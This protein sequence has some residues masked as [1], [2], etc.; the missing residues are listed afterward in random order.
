L[1]T[2][3]ILFGLGFLLSTLLSAQEVEYTHPELDWYTIR[4]EHFQ[5][6]YHQGAERSARVVAKVAEDIYDPVTSFYDWAPDGN[7]HFI[8]KDHDDNSNGAAYYYDNKVEIWAPQMRFILRG[9]HNW[10]RNVVTHEFTHMI[11]LGAIRKITRRIPSF[12]LQLIGYE[13]EKRPDV[14]Y[15]YPNRLA[16]YPLPMTVIPM[17]LAEGAAQFQVPGLDYDRWDSHRDMLIRTAVLSGELLDYDEMGVFGKN[18]L[19]NERTYNAGYA[20][21]RYIA[22]RWGASS[23]NEISRHM[24]RTLSFGA[25]G[26]LERVIGMDADR[27]YSIWSKHLE[28]FYGQKCSR[29]LQNRTEGRILTA[30]GI[31]NIAPVWS[32]EGRYLAYCGSRSSD[33]LT[34]TRLMLYEKETGKHHTLKPQVNSRLSW[35]ADGSRILYAR[36]RRS[37][38]HSHF[39][40]LHVYDVERRREKRLTHSLRAADPDWAADGRI[41]CVVQSDGTD[42]LVLLSETGESEKNLTGYSNGEALYSPRWSPDGSAIIFGRAD[43]HGRDLYKIE[44][45]SGA[46]TPILQSAGDARDA[47]YTP[48][49]KRILF[50]WDR[51]G[52]FNIYS[53]N[54]DGSDLRLWTN[55]AGGAFMPSLSADGSLAYS[56]FVTGG[57]K[58]ALLEEPKPLDSELASYRE[59]RVS[60]AAPELEAAFENAAMDSARLFDDS[61]LP[62]ADPQPYGMT[63]GQL[64]FLPRVMIDS[65]RVKLGS[66]FYA[67][68]I[69]DR[70]SVLGGAAANARQEI[71][72]FALFAYRALGPELFL[73]LYGITRHTQQDIFIIEDYPKK[74]RVD[75]HFNIL[76]ADIGVQIR[77]REGQ[78]LR[79][80]L[81]HQRYTSQI[82]DFVFRDVTFVSPSN[83]YFIGN[84]LSLRW[85]LD[86]VAPGLYSSINP[87]A[88]RRI[89]LGVTREQN[90]FFEDF[91]TDNDYGTPQEVYSDFNH[92]RLDLDWI[93]YLRPPWAGS[94]ALSAQIRAGWI[95]RPVDSF[96]YFF[97]GGMPGLRGYPFYSIEGRKMVMGRFSYRFP[98]FRRWQRRFLHLTT[99]AL[100]L[101]TFFDVGDAF[102]RDTIDFAQLKKSFGFGIRLHAF[103][104]FGFPTALNVD[105]AYGL[106]RFEI[107]D[108]RYGREWRYYVT[109]LFD[110]LD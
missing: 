54:P 58:I 35:S 13:A 47:C 61:K 56:L 11:Q 86:Q 49:G 18:S 108:I 41:V 105:A 75:V 78:T 8:I 101:G 23:L 59:L 32:P 29:I 83:T 21:V 60:E 2:F 25:R 44:L 85:R 38:H 70:Y 97:A 43:R 84:H 42:N 51:T 33:Y 5:I 64:T 99:N 30:K 48:D 71:D 3:L 68:D 22:H 39:Y 98:L 76:E 37:A 17:W 45:S 79:L 1:R 19:G 40:D 110:F 20:L 53:I 27:L 82:G 87:A 103:S 66:Y 14:L 69:L 90:K 91:A 80:A 55:T 15:G 6:H 109:L 102:D 88:G 24:S 46:V 52:I 12:Y 104:F 106:D 7:I 4:T 73:E 100:Y 72:A 34:L 62:P 50:S 10:L 28:S 31:G 94:H 74:V 63:Y 9:T 67:S 16:S 95:D 89:E 107:G 65:S 36:R 93:E 92:F 77:P 81:A 57:Y 96:F 26:A